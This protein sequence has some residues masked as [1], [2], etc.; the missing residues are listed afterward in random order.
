M[1]VKIKDLKTFD[2]FRFHRQNAVCLGNNYYMYMKHYIPNKHWDCDL[3]K[4]VVV[5]GNM[6]AKF[7][8]LNL[9]DYCI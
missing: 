6:E 8:N 1:K 5:L 4:R 3:D 7:M 2:L 9:E